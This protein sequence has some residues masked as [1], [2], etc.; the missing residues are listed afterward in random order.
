MLLVVSTD[1]RPVSIVSSFASCFFTASFTFKPTI[2]LAKVICVP[3]SNRASAW[4]ISS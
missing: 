4:R 2:G 1:R 3:I